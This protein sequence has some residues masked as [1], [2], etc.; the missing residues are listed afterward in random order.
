MEK[1]EFL[2]EVGLEPEEMEV[3]DSVSS[4]KSIST[5]KPSLDNQL[6]KAE[7][8]KGEIPSGK[9]ARRFFEETVIR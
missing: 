1:G 7:I 4:A 9:V 5:K 3:H 2:K 6:N 8:I